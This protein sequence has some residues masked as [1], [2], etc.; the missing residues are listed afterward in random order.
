[1]WRGETWRVPGGR[2][3]KEKKRR[4]RVRIFAPR[5]VAREGGGFLAT[6][7]DPEREC[8]GGRRAPLCKRARVVCQ[9][10]VVRLRAWAV[11]GCRGGVL[12]TLTSAASGLLALRPPWTC[13][14]SHVAL[15]I[16]RVGSH[17][18]ASC[19]PARE[20]TSSS[21]SILHRASTDGSSPTSRPVASEASRRIG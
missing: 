20:P 21:R 17:R 7:M 1:M 10:R 2:V 15:R 3:K 6:S 16:Q 9:C 12:G 19:R 11:G 18:R 8:G 5:V 13:V 4:Y 14:A